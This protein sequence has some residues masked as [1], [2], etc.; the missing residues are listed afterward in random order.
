MFLCYKNTLIPAGMAILQGVP[1][2]DPARTKGTSLPFLDRKPWTSLSAL[3]PDQ[4]AFAPF[5]NLTEGDFGSPWTHRGA[6]RRSTTTNAF[7]A[8]DP[9]GRV[10]PLP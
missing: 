6:F 5:G 10:S 7:R 3:D 8:L 1:P 2:L 9:R 4:R